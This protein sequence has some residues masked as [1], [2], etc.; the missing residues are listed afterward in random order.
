MFL[1][2]TARTKPGEGASERRL[3]AVHSLASSSSRS[4]PP[5]VPSECSEAPFFAFYVAGPL[6][7]SVFVGADWPRQICA[8]SAADFIKPQLMDFL[9]EQCETIHIKWARQGTIGTFITPFTI[10]AGSALSF[11]AYS[12]LGLGRAVRPR[13]TVPDLHVVQNTPV[14]T[15]TCQTVTF[16][17]LLDVDATV[18]GG[19]LSQYGFI[20]QCTDLSVG[21]TSVHPDELSLSWAFPFFLSLVSSDGQMWSNG[22]FHAG[23][24]GPNDCLAPGT[25][26]NSKAHALAVGAG[27]GGAF[28]AGIYGALVT[29]LFLRYRH[30]IW[31]SQAPVTVIT[32]AEEVVELPPRYQNDRV[33][34]AV[35]EKA[36]PEEQMRVASSSP[37]SSFALS[38]L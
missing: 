28:G 18:P 36:E 31:K 19:P 35:R 38:S 30:K 25:I 6:T 9:S 5:L 37:L 4:L 23:G 34:P 3:H 14:A 13:D 11:I 15:P 1:L 8:P 33:L 21:E 32:D 16:P 2:L 29:F 7:R 17:T 10:G 26:S 20:N 22:P 27:V 24:F 12:E